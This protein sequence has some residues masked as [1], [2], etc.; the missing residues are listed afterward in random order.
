[1]GFS[2]PSTLPMVFSLS[3]T[4]PHQG[5]KQ[6]L[7]VAQKIG[8]LQ[9][10]CG[11]AQSAEDFVSQFKFGLTEVVYCWARGMVSQDCL[12]SM[13]VCHAAINCVS[14]PSVYGRV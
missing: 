3:L 12:S 8:D 6:V 11:I 14:C 9:R 5:I 13:T 1:M 4:L 2:S 10:E 7:C